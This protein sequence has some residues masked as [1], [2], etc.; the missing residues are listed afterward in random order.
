MRNSHHPILWCE[1]RTTLPLCA[2]F[3]D[4]HPYPPQS[5]ASEP[6]FFAPLWLRPEEALPQLPRAIRE[7]PLCGPHLMH[8]HIYLILPLRADTIR[9]EHLPHLWPLHKFRLGVLLQKEPRLQSQETHPEHLGIHSLNLLPPGALEPA[10]PLRATPI[11]DREHFMSRH[12][13]ITLFCASRLTCGIHTAYLRGTI[14][15]PL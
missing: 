11:A 5:Q 8:P 7:P 10:R 15:Y 3:W 6:H 2:N 13:L 14:L 1:I 12:I 4:F 9:G